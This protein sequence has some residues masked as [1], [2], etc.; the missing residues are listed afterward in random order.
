[1]FDEGGP[2]S[3][4]AR[5]VMSGQTHSR[6]FFSFLGAMRGSDALLYPAFLW[7]SIISVT[8]GGCTEAV[9][10]VQRVQVTKVAA[11]LLG[12]PPLLPL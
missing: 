10:Q 11:S 1:M 5:W 7:F 4:A 6:F 8:E 3:W 12:P 9:R 2:P